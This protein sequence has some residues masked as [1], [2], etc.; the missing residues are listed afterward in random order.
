MSAIPLSSNTSPIGV[1]WGKSTTVRDK[2]SDSYSA[3]GKVSYEL[4]DGIQK[5]KIRTVT[6]PPD[7]VRLERELAEILQECSV[8]N[9]NGYD[10]KS[11][12]RDS[13]RYV[14]AFLEVIPNDISYPELCAEPSG[15][16]TMV[17]QK[18]G[19]HVVIG[20]DGTGKIAWGGTG[21]DGRLFGD[22]IF[23]EEI[24]KVVLDILYPI[25]GKR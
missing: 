2:R 10:A 12:D 25:E 14:C 3:S 8:P 24:P 1:H 5:Q 7:D 23:S 16:L 20:I 4:L 19:Y 9:W 18:H 6:T 17:W 15:E 21:P 13:I 11:I 22:A